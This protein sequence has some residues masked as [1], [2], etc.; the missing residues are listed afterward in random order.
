MHFAKLTKD[1]ETEYTAE[2]PRY[3][4][5]VAEIA[6][7]PEIN[8]LTTYYDNKAANNYVTEGKTELQITV[9][10][11]PAALAAEILGKHY[12]ATTGR[13]Y[14]EELPILPNV[15]LDLGTTWARTDS[16]TTGT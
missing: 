13:V 7:E 11:I 12:D 6:G 1:D 3:L 16:V 8:N 4:A 14:D 15:R 9:S 2:V 5:P 10:N